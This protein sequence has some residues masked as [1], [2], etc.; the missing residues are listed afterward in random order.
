MTLLVHAESQILLIELTGKKQSIE[1]RDSLALFKTQ[2]R[3]SL[4]QI[5]PLTHNIVT[6]GYLCVS[7]FRVSVPMFSFK[8][9]FHIDL[10][11]FVLLSS[12]VNSCSQ[13]SRPLANVSH[14]TWSNP[15]GYPH[16]HTHR[17]ITIT[18]FL[19]SFLSLSISLSHPFYFSYSQSV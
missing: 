11:G 13:Y 9:H 15:P 2:T 17:H 5:V 7:C 10:S 16:T 6:R 18:S 8:S 3:H 19:S 12:S 4:V 1:H 14:L